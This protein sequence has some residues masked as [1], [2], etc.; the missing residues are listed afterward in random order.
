MHLDGLLGDQQIR[1]IALTAA[2][3]VCEGAMEDSAAEIAASNDQREVRV[4]NTTLRL[5]ERYVDFIK[6]GRL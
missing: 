4:G 2:A 6:H 3:Q 5:A 1:A